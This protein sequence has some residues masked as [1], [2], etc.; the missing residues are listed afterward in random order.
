M[1]L[2]VKHSTQVMNS[3]SR[4]MEPCLGLHTEH[5][6]RLGFSP[7]PSAP[8]SSVHVLIKQKQSNL[9]KYITTVICNLRNLPGE[10]TVPH[11]I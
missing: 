1:A 5:G 11:N 8:P 7:S 4:V 9:K 6:A 3:G 2:S 10:N